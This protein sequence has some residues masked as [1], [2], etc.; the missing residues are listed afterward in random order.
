MFPKKLLICGEKCDTIKPMKKFKTE[1]TMNSVLSNNIRHYRRALG[2]TQQAL[3]ERLFVSPQTVSK[4]ESGLSEP[5]ADKLCALSDAFGISLDNLVRIPNYTSQRAYIAVDGGGTKTDFVLFLENGDI[6]DRLIL[7]GCNPNAYGIVHTEKILS[8]GIDRFVRMGAKV[9]AVFAGIS[10]A[11]VGNN[12]AMLNEFLKERYPYLK[13][14]VEG[15][16]HNVIGSVVEVDKCIAVICGTG[17]VVYAYDGDLLRRFGGW[18]Y[19]FDSAGSGFDI[20]RELFRYCLE[21]EDLGNTEDEIYREL[22]NMVGGHIFDNISVIYSKGKDYVASFA[23]MV[24][25]FCDSGNEVAIAIVMQTAERISELINRAH[26]SGNCGN[27]AIIAGGLT[28]RK[29]IL[30][31]MVRKNL[32]SGIQLVFADQPPIFGAAV[33]CMKLFS[34]NFDKEFFA[35]NFLRALSNRS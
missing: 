26:E 22:C 19:L 7:G 32:K 31:P 12:R 18:G 21:C 25:R 34:N 17:S 11:A 35:D 28:S 6:I 15:D 29:D 30:E 5:D 10:G 3:A 27:T 2:I 24:F 13:C 14:C 9:S 20:G 1:K 33:K 4:W 16:I 23:P 8:D